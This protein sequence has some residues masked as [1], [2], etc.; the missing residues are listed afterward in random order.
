MF[1]CKNQ[2]SVT[3]LIVPFGIFQA[4]IFDEEVKVIL[5]PCFDGK[6]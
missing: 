5:M 2:A 3:L 4:D 1:Y 6:I